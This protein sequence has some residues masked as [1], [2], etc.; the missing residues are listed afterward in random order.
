MATQLPG[1]G[2]QS[3]DP[4]DVLEA[5][6]E[7]VLSDF[8]SGG[9]DWADLEEMLTEGYGRLLAVETLLLRLDQQVGTQNGHSGEGNPELDEFR[10]TLVADA[11]RLRDNLGRFRNRGL[12][13]R[14]RRFPLPPL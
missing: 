4:L 11:A 14:R 2:A 9:T 3:Y 5:Q 12:E 13:A 10:Q 8:E 7:E 6:I 1:E